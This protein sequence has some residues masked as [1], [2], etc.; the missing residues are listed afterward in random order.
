MNELEKIRLLLELIVEGHRTLGRVGHTHLQK[1]VYLLQEAKEEPFG[2]DFRM[3]HYGP[4]SRELW[5]TLCTMRDLGLIS[6]KRY[7]HP[8][9]YGYDIS[10][11]EGQ[12][13]DKFREVSSKMSSE[14]DMSKRIAEYRNGHTELLQFFEEHQSGGT[15]YLEL[16]GT[17]HFVHKMLA[18]YEDHPSDDEIV[19][20]VGELKDQLS[21][22]QIRG[23]LKTL[24]KK[25]FLQD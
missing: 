16:V 5:G 7:P 12:V 13:L 18:L 24:R 17:T 14:S 19:A 1:L 22:P 2:Y 20:R 11:S 15:R 4:Y 10:E 8:F 25:H 9:G 6:I 3:H 23:A 21:E